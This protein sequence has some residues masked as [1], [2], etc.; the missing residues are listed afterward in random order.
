MNSLIKHGTKRRLVW[1]LAAISCAML[2]VIC[3][4]VTAVIEIPTDFAAHVEVVFK[5]NSIP[6]ELDSGKWNA[7]YYRSPAYAMILSQRILFMDAQ[8]NGYFCSITYFPI[9]KLFAWEQNV[10]DPSMVGLQ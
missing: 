3:I 5:K 4:P 2:S 10:G 7:T 9:L 1:L 6:A 8:E